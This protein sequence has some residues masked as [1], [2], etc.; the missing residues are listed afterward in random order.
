MIFQQDVIDAIDAADAEFAWCWEC[1]QKLRRHEIE[2]RD[3][4]DFQVRLIRAFT[5]LDRAYRAVKAE[6]GRL[7]GRKSRYQPSWFGSRMK[8][9]DL[10]LS[11][12]KQALGI[13]RSLGDGFAWIFYRDE[14]A[15]LEE[16]AQEQRQLLL[17]PNV[18]G[19]GERAFVE[20]LQGLGGTFV[21]YHAVTSFLR[22]GDVS[23]FDPRAGR[24]TTIGE[25]KTRHVGGDT[26]H[27]TLGF[28]AGDKNNPILQQAEHAIGQAKSDPTPHEILDGITQQTL[29]RQVDQIAKALKKQES[30]TENVKLK[31]QADFHF[32][33]FADVVRRSHLRAFEFRKGGAGLVLGAWR[34]RKSESLGQRLFAKKGNV[35]RTLEPA[36]QVVQE[37]LDP[38]LSDNCLLVGSVGSYESGFPTMLVGGVPLM[39][40]PVEKDA[41]R[42][43]LFGHVIVV[44]LFNPAQLWALLRE[45]GFIIA[46][47][48]RSQVTQIHRQIGD[49]R[50]EISNFSYFERLVQDALMDEMAIVKMIEAL[51]EQANAAAGISHLERIF[52]RGSGFDVKKTTLTPAKSH[53]SPPVLDK[54]YLCYEGAFG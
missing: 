18:G 36:R 43:V 5:K 31:T 21:L 11:A 53:I 12:I 51:A 1:F 30:S 50:F 46:T 8:S 19:I 39:W 25:I 29:K 52:D 22:L 27:I 35:E 42:D 40:W 6:Q 48:N 47:N 37:V 9:L 32:D 34:F 41:L 10:Y 44:T 38:K 28:I 13:G 49:K 45:R 3:L 2:V 54:A 7:I 4:I 26:Y 17:P 15:L 33:V 14:A 23:F 20:K 24:I 16:H